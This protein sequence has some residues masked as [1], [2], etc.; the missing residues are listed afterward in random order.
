[1]RKREFAIFLAR[2]II[3]NIPWICVTL[4]DTPRDS[5]IYRARDNVYVA[6]T[7]HDNVHKEPLQRQSSSFLITMIKARVN[8]GYGQEAAG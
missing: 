4:L 6:R 5:A 1:M 2:K 7:K 3:P 8:Y